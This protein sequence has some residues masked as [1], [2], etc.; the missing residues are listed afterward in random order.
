MRYKHYLLMVL[1][2]LS[3]LIMFGQTKQEA[4]VDA[5]SKGEYK[6]AITLYEELAKD[7]EA[8]S[9]Y[10]NL[11]N[12]YYKDGQ[13]AKA[14]LNYER[15]LLLNPSMS[16]ARFNLEMAQQKVVDKIETIDEFFLTSWKHSIQ[17]LMSVGSWSI[18]AIVLFFMFIA[19]LLAFLFI[20]IV[21]VK[22]VSFFSALVVLCFCIMA[23]VF[24]S[25][26]KK[27]QLNRTGAIIMTPTVT[28][29]SSP[30]QSGTDLFILHEGT[31]VNIRSRLGDWSEIILGNGN[32]G[33][34]PS[35]S[36]EVI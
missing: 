2:S 4:A 12:A 29:K 33:W 17:N 34:L 5:Y 14:I 16:D 3:V 26:L 11:G 15:A 13:I 27:K 28:I 6:T 24:A 1:F 31:K 36:F 32:I 10:Y 20:R 7:G 35:K 25:D 19:F 21:W 22:K 9:L 23:N 30:D 8:A 18:G